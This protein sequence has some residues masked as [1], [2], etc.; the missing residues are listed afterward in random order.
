[1][2]VLRIVP[3]LDFGGVEQVLANSIFSLIESSKMELMIIVLGDGGRVEKEL[4][5]K[6]VKVILYKQNPKI[7][8]F[9]ILFKLLQFIKEFEPDVIHCQGAEANFHG[10]IA[11][12]LA[13]VPVRIGEEIGFPN[14]H[15]YWKYIF[16]FVY[17]YATKVIAISHAVKDRIV[18]LGE[19]K[20]E[21]VA[22]VY[23]PVTFEDSSLDLDPDRHQD[24]NDK[25]KPLS[26]LDAYLC[27]SQTD[28]E[29]PFVFVSTCRL[30]PVKNL[31]RLIRAFEKL[32]QDFPEKPMKLLIVGDGPLK[33]SLEN[34]VKE[35]EMKD[36][37]I[38]SGFQE[39]VLPFL[40]KADVFVLPSLSEGSSV[41]LVEAMLMRLPSIVTKVGGTVEILGD[42]NSG[43]LVDPLSEESIFEALSF[44]INL[45][46]AQMIEMGKRAE[47]EAK[48]FST[49]N[50][51]KNLLEVY[52]RKKS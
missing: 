36:S 20:N 9:K 38:F 45:P 33:E 5:E 32:R 17:Q 25:D 51:L 21:K 47:L 2:K 44:F 29:K 6:G 15:S 39:N 50:Y 31:D 10:L 35:L 49:D 28:G 12:K 42:S 1:M 46:E 19:V 11:A 40:E 3:F 13:G 48:R 14:H 4:V 37:V 52:G 30:V 43:R 27:R 26:V 23:N 8:N 18:E 7:P 22:V 24:L 16:R 41:S 34:L